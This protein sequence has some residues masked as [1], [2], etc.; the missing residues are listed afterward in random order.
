MNENVYICLTE[1]PVFAKGKKQHSYV[2]HHQRSFISKS[3]LPVVYYSLIFSLLYLLLY[4]DCAECCR[5]N[6]L[7]DLYRKYH[8][9]SIVLHG[10]LF[11]STN[12]CFKLSWALWNKTYNNSCI[13]RKCG[14]WLYESML[15]TV[16]YTQ[17]FRA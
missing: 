8:L 1:Y 5:K 12:E 16:N 14:K 9:C 7:N 11:Q 6:E 10:S 13:F 2:V 3:E 4:C 17:D 15:N